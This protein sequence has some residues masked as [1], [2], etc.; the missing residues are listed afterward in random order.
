VL[1][2]EKFLGV[3]FGLYFHPILRH[4]RK[5]KID[6]AINSSA[7]FSSRAIYLML[8]SGAEKISAVAS[9]NKK[10]IWN[11]FIDNKI[12]IPL[13]KELHQIQKISL[14]FKQNR[15]PFKLPK[16]FTSRKISQPRVLLCPHSSS[17]KNQWDITN[18]ILLFNSLRKNNVEVDVCLPRQSAFGSLFEREINY[19]QDTKSL[20]NLI[21]EYD[22]VISQEGG[23]G[24][25]AAALSKSLITISSP[26]LKIRWKPWLKNSD[27]IQANHNI[28]NIKVSLILK[29]IAKYLNQ[30]K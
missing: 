29:K 13:K 6:F 15:L 11:T 10:N 9:N 26:N 27:F 8:C 28:S 25:I 21:K 2:K 22:L 20:I 24:H 23:I 7:S 16:K 3:Y 30:K 17:L 1:D 5:E 18:W 12:E 19:P 14:I 4:I